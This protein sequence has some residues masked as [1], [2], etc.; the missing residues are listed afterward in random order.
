MP[1]IVLS[2]RQRA[3][4]LKR[5]ALHCKYEKAVALYAETDMPLKKIAEACHHSPGA[6]GTYLRRHW[7]EL[8]LSRH[9]IQV[10]GKDP[11]AVKILAAGQQSMN[12]HS[13]YKDAVAACDSLDYIE[14]NVSQ[15]A[16][17]FG[18]DGTALANFMRT[19]YPDIPV[20][21][22]NLRRKLGINDNIQRGARPECSA[23][24]ADA[25]ELYSTTDMTVPEV[26]DCCQVSAG[27]LGQHLRF[28]HKEVLEQKRQQ[29]RQ[30]KAQPR[31]TAGGLLGNG[32][33]YRPALA[34]VEKYA[35]ATALYKDTQLTMKEIVRRTGVT[36][37]GFRSYLHLWHRDLVLERLGID[38]EVDV[39]TDLRKA[40]KRTK[41]VAAK[42]EK[43]I[44]SLKQN[45]RP[46]AHVAAEFGF[47]PESFR[48]YIH[49]HEPEIAG[50]LGMTKTGSG[51]TVSRRSEEKYAEAVK[52]Y[53][54][55]TE[56]LTSIA[57]RLGLT[58][59]SVG[60]F[61]RRNYPEVIARHQELLARSRTN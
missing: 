60:G 31:K 19:H 23:Q 32:K 16:R 52:L 12:A 57:R 4:L 21:R 9:H 58:Y 39:H 37:E 30:A 8:V 55:T 25:V 26:A 22:E 6:L 54:T 17:K 24:Y 20:K 5:H 56:D 33:R 7:R 53:E 27:G 51:K 29:R 18:L 47:H 28:Y 43:A 48:E 11:H 42:Y 14:F 1:D 59:N 10:G 36:Q 40:R 13:K 34:T 61:I 41:T 45:P 35:E 50:R 15:V 38:G 46:I 44:E 2:A 3:A 49:K